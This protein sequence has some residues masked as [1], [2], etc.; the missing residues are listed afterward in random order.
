MSP[1]SGP[2]GCSCA[3]YRSCKKTASTLSKPAFSCPWATT[4]CW[5]W[6]APSLTSAAPWTAAPLSS[7][8]AGPPTTPSRPRAPPIIASSTAMGQMQEM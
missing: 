3:S 7:P 5:T 8:T 6:A 1:P 4:G 2:S